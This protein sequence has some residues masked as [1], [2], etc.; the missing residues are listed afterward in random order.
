MEKH[1]LQTIPQDSRINNT[2]IALII[3]ILSWSSLWISY[4]KD[5]ENSSSILI[6]RCREP[7]QKDLIH[8]LIELLLTATTLLNI[9]AQLDAS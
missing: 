8:T 7:K 4:T 5:I 9:P 6:S 1:S 2:I 3:G